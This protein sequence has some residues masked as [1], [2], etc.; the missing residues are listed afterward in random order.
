M[1]RAYDKYDP[2]LFKTGT[3]RH[4]G[5][6]FERTT[7]PYYHKLTVKVHRLYYIELT[8][9]KTNKAL[10]TTRP[11]GFALFVL[12]KQEIVVRVTP[13]MNG[14]DAVVEQR[15]EGVDI[16]LVRSGNEDAVVVQLRHPRPISI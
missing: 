12:L 8:L 5:D 10:L 9:K 14:F 6:F 13:D 1:C 4:Y 2:N 15:L 3:N 16:G 11:E 7:T